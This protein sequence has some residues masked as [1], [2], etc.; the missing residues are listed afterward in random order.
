MGCLIEINVYIRYTDNVFSS[1]FE[2]VRFIL[3]F[4]LFQRG[5]FVLKFLI[6]KKYFYNRVCSNLLQLS[7]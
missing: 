6:R 7:F 4:L 2:P 5:F 3:F 1:F